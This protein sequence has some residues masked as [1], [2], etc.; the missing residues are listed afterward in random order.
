LT[1]EYNEIELGGFLRLDDQHALF[2]ARARG[3]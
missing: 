2:N 3:I 1:G